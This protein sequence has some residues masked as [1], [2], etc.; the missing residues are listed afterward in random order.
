MT[1]WSG[2]IVVVLIFGIFIQD[3]KIGK[4]D[5]A[6]AGRNSSGPGGAALGHPLAQALDLLYSLSAGQAAAS[7][8]QAAGHAGHAGQGQ[9]AASPAQLPHQ[10]TQS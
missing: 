10:L 7:A 4:I 3:V 9:A 1:K 6:Q 5:C 2:P 8:G